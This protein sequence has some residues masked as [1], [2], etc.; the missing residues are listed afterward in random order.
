MYDNHQ[1]TELRWQTLSFLSDFNTI[2][3]DYYWYVFN[4]VNISPD[5]N[6]HTVKCLGYKYSVP[7]CGEGFLTWQ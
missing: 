5:H 4:F 3:Y 1:E 6:K 7:F 2:Y